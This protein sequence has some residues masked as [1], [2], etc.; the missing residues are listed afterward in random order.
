MKLYTKHIHEDVDLRIEDGERETLEN[1]IAILED[2]KKNLET[3]AAQRDGG[4][5]V[6][7]S[8]V[9]NIN[10]DKISSLADDISELLDN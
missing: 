3:R 5:S 1:A 10:F 2:I 7:F 9:T 4:Y 8:N 6:E